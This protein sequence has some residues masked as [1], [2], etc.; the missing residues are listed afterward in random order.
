M[1]TSPP[2]E[3]GTLVDLVEDRVA[4]KGNEPLVHFMDQ[5]YSYR[6]MVDNADAVADQLIDR[7]IS[8]GDKVA[9][10][11][12]NSPEYLAVWFGIAKAGAVM[13]PL[14]V[15]LLSDRIEYILRDSA[16]NAIVL[17]NGTRE[18]YQTIRDAVEVERE[19]S[20]GEQNNTAVFTEPID[21]SGSDTVASISRSPKRSDP[22]SI[23][24]TS[25]TTGEPKGVLLPHFS[26][27][28]TGW[29]F[30]FNALDLDETDRLFTSLPLF[31]LNAQQTTVMGS[32]C[33]G[34][35]F[36]LEREF[37]P[38]TFWDRLRRYDVTVFNYLGTMI[39][40]LY[41]QEQ[42]PDDDDNPAIYGV[43]AEAPVELLGD[44]ETRFDVQL[45]EGY[46]L[47]ETA[48]IAT[49]NPVDDPRHGSIGKSLSYTEVEVVDQDDRP[50]PPG[51]IGEITVR[52]TEPN[53]FMSG[54][55]GRP[56]ETVS[57]WRNLRLHTGDLGYKDDDGYFY[58]VDRKDY[59]IR[60]HGTILSSFE[61]E[62][63]INDHP[64]VRETAV[65]GVSDGQGEEHVTAVIVPKPETGVTPVEITDYCTQRLEYYKIPRYVKIVKDVP[66]TPTERIKKHELA[67]Q[68]LTDAWDRE[69][70]YELTG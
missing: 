26:Y 45:I 68:N 40:N 70:G 8:K 34:T 49:I 4:D 61:I 16:A 47:T 11:L 56:E 55:Y 36:V 46:G 43:G 51:E 54:Y 42:T 65:F 37:N 58:F 62:N 31:H 35:D 33:A 53:S 9:T 60:R 22:M 67:D 27:V 7:G 48:T 5:T 52:F 13:V 25:G 41:K 18:A 29:E 24:Y 21:V 17:E 59:A 1:S 32:I 15:H 10:L 12:H 57:A 23:L 3:F 69:V 38:S 6:E 20:L 2:D 30:A 44:F 50:L 28:N 66:K 14:G 39:T 19:F 63:V 64:D